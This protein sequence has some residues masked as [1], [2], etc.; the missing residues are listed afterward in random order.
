V[1]TECTVLM[2]R[3]YKPHC[4]TVTNILSLKLYTTSDPVTDA[5]KT[6]NLANKK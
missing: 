1:P 3:E 4:G 2:I 6:D 5:N